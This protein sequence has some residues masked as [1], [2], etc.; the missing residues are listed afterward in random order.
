MQRLRWVS[1]TSQKISKFLD[2][3]SQL[4]SKGKEPSSKE[5]SCSLEF[6][7]S[8]MLFTKSCLK[9][10]LTK[11]KWGKYMGRIIRQTLLLMLN[12]GHANL[13]KESQR[14]TVKCAFMDFTRLTGVQ[15]NA[16]NAWTTQ[17]AKALMKSWLTKVFGDNPSTLQRFMNVKRNLPVLEVIM[18]TWPTLSCVMKVT[19]EF[20]VL[21]VLWLMECSIKDRDQQVVGN[22]QQRQTTSSEWLDFLPC[23][24]F[25]CSFW[26]SLIL[27]RNENLTFQ[28]CSELSWT[29][30]KYQQP[31]WVSNFNF[32]KSC[33]Q[34]SHPSKSL[35]KVLKWS[36]PMIALLKVR[37]WICLDQA[38]ICL[39]YL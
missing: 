33:W 18:K 5:L 16:L 25:G 32:L 12:T 2:K 24:F 37:N 9:T 27:S 8:L 1:L 15:K 13:E 30:F 31:P 34:Y 17:D 19:K 6:L 10:E 11:K 36:Y 21:N 23:L 26:F 14:T 4:P 20:Y 39:K 35:G 29:T 3:L 7:I 38:N 22:A 28:L